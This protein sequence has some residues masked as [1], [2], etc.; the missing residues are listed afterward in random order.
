MS[1]SIGNGFLLA[2]GMG[3]AG[4]VAS[5]SLSSVLDCSCKP[6]QNMTGVENEALVIAGGIKAVYLMAFE[7]CC[8]S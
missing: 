4:V 3:V 1:C 5:C 7:S 8:L 2:V 6:R